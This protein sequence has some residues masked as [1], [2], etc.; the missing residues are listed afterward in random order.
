[1]LAEAFDWPLAAVAIAL[2][3]CNSV[4]LE[5]ISELTHHVLRRE[6]R[7]TFTNCIKHDHIVLYVGDRARHAFGAAADSDRRKPN[8]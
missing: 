2:Y 8:N 1:M 7:T 3:F 4:G 6:W 5:Q